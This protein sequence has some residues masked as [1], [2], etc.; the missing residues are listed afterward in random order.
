MVDN[1][2]QSLPYGKAG[3]RTKAAR[4]SA[5]TLNPGLTNNAFKERYMAFSRFTGGF[6]LLQ[7]AG[8]L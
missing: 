5:T 3:P 1:P 4:T 2:N 6:R 8:A 7:A